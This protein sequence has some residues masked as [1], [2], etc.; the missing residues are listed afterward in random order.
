MVV[1]ALCSEQSALHESRQGGRGGRRSYSRRRMARPDPDEE[2]MQCGNEQVREV[3]ESNQELKDERQSR[4][5]RPAAAEVRC[6]EDRQS[7]SATQ[8]RRHGSTPAA[9]ALRAGC[10]MPRSKCI[11]PP[12]RTS[13][14]AHSMPIRAPWEM[15]GGSGMPQLRSVTRWAAGTPACSACC[16]GAWRWRRRRGGRPWRRSGSGQACASRRLMSRCSAISGG[17]AEQNP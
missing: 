6:K 2:R 3:S 5:G 7:A 12:G 10:G 9:N 8:G 11:T 14:G 16:W 1:E 13:H 17:G 15:L 4:R